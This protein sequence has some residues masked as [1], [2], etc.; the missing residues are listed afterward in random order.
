MAWGLPSNTPLLTWLEEMAR[1]FSSSHM[2]GDRPPSIRRPKPC[3]AM[4]LIS[5]R[6]TLSRGQSSLGRVPQDPLLWLLERFMKIW[7][8]GTNEWT[9]SFMQAMSSGQHFHF[10]LSPFLFLIKQD[11][12]ENFITYVPFDKPKRALTFQPKWREA[13]FIWQPSRA[14]VKHIQPN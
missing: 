11:S 13:Y 14:S 1:V 4:T 6:W 7:L 5:G 9:D 2:S 10:S 3:P 8:N 12:Y